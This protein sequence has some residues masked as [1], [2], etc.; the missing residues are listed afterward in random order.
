MGRR[1]YRG[2]STG[3]IQRCAL[4]GAPPPVRPSGARPPT[5]H[6]PLDTAGS[7]RSRLW[8]GSSGHVLVKLRVPRSDAIDG[9][10]AR[11]LRSGRPQPEPQL[12]VVEELDDPVGQALDVPG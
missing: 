12:L 4:R 2:A 7:P 6:P 9:E 10:R 11:S 8:R 3:R 1:G 5:L